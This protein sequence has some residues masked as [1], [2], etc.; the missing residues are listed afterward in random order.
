[1]GLNRAIFS[2]SLALLITISASGI[3]QTTGAREVQ[4]YE[5]ESAEGRLLGFYSSSLAFTPLGTAS[6]NKDR[7][8]SA[9]LSLEMGY[10]PHLNGAQRSAGFDKP[11]AS[12]L[13][14][15]LPRP[16]VTILLP[17]H[18]EI[19]G[20]WLP[21]VRVQDARANLF[22][23]SLK[24]SFALGRFAFSPR[25][26]FMDGRIEG[27][28]TCNRSL[29]EGSVSDIQYFAFVCHANESEDRFEPRHLAFDVTLS[30]GPRVWQAESYLG[31]GV[32]REWTRFDIGVIR[33][34]GSRDPDHPILEM[35]ATRAYGVIGLQWDPVGR[36]RYAA[37]VG[38][39]PG[40]LV[41]GRIMMGWRLR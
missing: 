34:D 4:R 16:R 23:A 1:M 26:T 22:A 33:S 29:G 19:E 27:A 13:S 24:R 8:L 36:A 10:I 21:P 2:A 15:I 38:Y 7:S 18:F 25:L 28:I 30:R 40:S 14:P 32:R 9:E 6:L 39:T 17:A 12:N 31:V 41:T 5:L 37:E 20:S 35:D 11:E 3:A